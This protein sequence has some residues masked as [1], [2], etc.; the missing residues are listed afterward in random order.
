MSLQTNEKKNENAIE[1]KLAEKTVTLQ[2]AMRKIREQQQF[3]SQ[4]T[5]S[6]FKL[7]DV[8]TTS[9]QYK[10]HVTNY[11]LSKTTSVKMK[12]SRT[13]LTGKRDADLAKLIDLRAQIY[14]DTQRLAAMTLVINDR[15]KAT[16]DRT[17]LEDE[18]DEIR[19]RQ[20]NDKNEIKDLN[21]KI[22]DTRKKKKRRI[23]AVEEVKDDFV[24]EDGELDSDQ[25]QEAR[26]AGA[27]ARLGS[28][29]P[30]VDAPPPPVYRPS[31][32]Y[33]GVPD[34]VLIRLANEVYPMVKPIVTR[35][36]ALIRLQTHRSTASSDSSSSVSSSSSSS[37]PAFTMRVASEMPPLDR[38]SVQR[39]PSPSSDRDGEAMSDGETDV[40]TSDTQQFHI[41]PTGN[42]QDV[43]P[44]RSRASSL[45]FSNEESM[46]AYADENTT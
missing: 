26:Q 38:Q 43:T 3:I 5:T 28:Q 14:N 1:Q 32:P 33:S 18:R 22:A 7:F 13:T 45:A 46:N 8:N 2:K 19:E 24:V 39:H 42:E 23:E 40:I 25:K 15:D 4:L 34:D 6:P 17:L 31:D 37:L 12:A 44:P 20:L 27:S 41:E 9:K 36:A 11:Q 10:K 35:G 21:A 16:N 30:L 29:P